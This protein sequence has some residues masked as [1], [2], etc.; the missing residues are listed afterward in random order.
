MRGRHAQRMGYTVSRTNV[1]LT[2]GVP[3]AN[4]LAQSHVLTKQRD[5]L[6]ATGRIYGHDFQDG[7]RTRHG[8]VTDIFYRCRHCPAHVQLRT[9]VPGFVKAPSVAEPC[10]QYWGRTAGSTA[11]MH[12]NQPSLLQPALPPLQIVAQR[13]SHTYV[14]LDSYADV[15]GHTARR[16]CTT[17]RRISTYEVALDEADAVAC[18]QPLDATLP[19][20]AAL[21]A[22]LDHRPH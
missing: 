11:P 22:R 18:Q 16:Y 15:Q 6:L 7:K 19:E 8:G 4:R 13:S 5:D 9:G 12:A 1:L 14:P 10:K 20:V 21:L 3:M 17:C 2:W